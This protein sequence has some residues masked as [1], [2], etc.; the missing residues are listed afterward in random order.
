[1]LSVS[2][3]LA[4][5]GFSL[6][7]VSSL[8]GMFFP[9]IQER[10]PRRK[11]PIRVSRR[12]NPHRHQ[13]RDR[14]WSPDQHGL[15]TEEARPV[16]NLLVQ[17]IDNV[18]Y[19]DL[20]VTEPTERGLSETLLSDASGLG[21]SPPSQPSRASMSPSEYS[22]RSESSAQTYDFPIVSSEESSPH[23]NSHMH[24]FR[25]RRT[26]KK[27]KSSIP[28]PSSTE[29]PILNNPSTIKKSKTFN[30]SPRTEKKGHL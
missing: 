5:V 21:S 24:G 8:L 22:E 6:S 26:W 4:S 17:P 23:H 3:L 30:K 12:K 15:V 11:D 18:T 19:D 9:D 28:M 25:I 27:S 16:F 29:L 20:I 2:F 7:V 14:S 1:M 13:N 10:P